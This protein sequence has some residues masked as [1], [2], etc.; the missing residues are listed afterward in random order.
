[1][2]EAAHH[3]R[4]A[5]GPPDGPGAFL[6]RRVHHARRILRDRC[7]RRDLAGIQ[8]MEDFE[9][10][11][12]EHQPETFLWYR[13]AAEAKQA[14][15]A[16][17]MEAMDLDLAGRTMLDV[18]PGHGDALDVAR[19]RGAA[20]L[21]FIEHEPVFFAYNRLKPRTSG[22]QLDHRRHLDRLPRD[23]YD[24]VW[25]KGSVVVEAL[26]RGAHLSFDPRT[27]AYM[28][29]DA[30]LDALAARAAP[31]GRIVLCP[32]WRHDGER[33]DA[34]EVEAH[35]LTRMLKA[36]GFAAMPAIDGHNSEPAYPVTFVKVCR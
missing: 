3:G 28:G 32:Y 16:D 17:V 9:R 1:M 21:A 19:D 15:F 22:W 14:E 30:W 29:P 20:R 34:E 25:S 4:V 18:G 5:D 8:S 12:D 23:A 10:Y 36:R 33:R 13:E 11:V 35:P 27:L 7:R 26:M 6:R 31:G 24:L 2:T